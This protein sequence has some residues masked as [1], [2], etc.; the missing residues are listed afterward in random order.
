MMQ[1]W[2]PSSRFLFSSQAAFASSCICSL[3][4]G[5]QRTNWPGE[6]LMGL[7]LLPTVTGK[8]RKGSKTTKHPV[9]IGQPLRSPDEGR[10][11]GRRVEE[12]WSRT[13]AEEGWGPRSR[14]ATR[15]CAGFVL[16]DCK[17]DHA[18]RL[19]WGCGEGGPGWQIKGKEG[20]SLD[21]CFHH[22]PWTS[23]GHMMMGHY[24]VTHGNTEAQ[25]ENVAC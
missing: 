14:A 6:P 18:H 25:G 15:S 19:P 22:Q 16:Q 9:C 3:D 2:W 8:D 13:G 5:G 1:C 17:G 21:L 11:E 12:E 4:S 7:S 23:Q 10:R 24:S 20:S